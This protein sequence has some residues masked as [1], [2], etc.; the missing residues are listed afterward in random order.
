VWNQLLNAF[1]AIDGWQVVRALFDIT[2]V[3]YFLY[4]LILLAKGRRAWWILIGLGVFF[5]LVLLSD[6]LGLVTLNFLLR[7][8]TPLGP[9]AI[10]VLFYPEL[11]EV[12]EKLGRA[13][14]WGGGL[15]V[16][17]T[18]TN[19]ETI[20]EIVRAVGIMAPLKTGALIVLEREVGLDEIVPNGTVIDAEVSSALLRTIFFDKSPLHDGAVL[21]RGDRIF[22]AECLLP[23]STTPNIA[24]NVHTRHRA[25]MGLSEVSDAIVVVVSEET[26]IISIA[27]NGKLQRGL[28]T[29]V[30]R[31]KLLEAFGHSPSR[32]GKRKG[33][34]SYLGLNRERGDMKNGA[35]ATPPA[36]VKVKETNP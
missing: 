6:V 34:R 24:Q 33:A 4:R 18:H 19:E 25:A 1:R 14:F 8:V 23:V 17:R 26:G 10:V 11:R 36:P 5:L 20:E 15:H 28:K 13:E 16:T 35:T 7:Q 30:L 31:T 12:L 21:V 29:D 2:L 32:K 9:V 27:Q 3:S 22:A